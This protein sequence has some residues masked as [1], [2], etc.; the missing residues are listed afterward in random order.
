MVTIMLAIE[1]GITQ[2]DFNA[3]FRAFGPSFRAELFGPAL[4]R[5]AAVV[6]KTA[7]RPGYGFRD[8]S[9][10]L[11][12]T[13]HSARIAARY[14]G[15][16]FKRGRSGVYAGGVLSGGREPTARQA[17]LV[18][19]GHLGPYPARP[20]P[21]LRL[22]L[23]S[24]EAQQRH[25][26]NASVKQRFSIV[27]NRFIKRLAKKSSTRF[28]RAQSAASF[29]QSGYARLVSLRGFGARRGLR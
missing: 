17:H 18:E 15:K 10:S 23:R 6:R 3:A 1:I 4:G 27:A 21:Y 29:S 11:R 14:G 13:I 2:D 7:K 24:T 5:S 12:K 8:R 19:A 26:F 16:K 9:G 25:E 28:I 20:H 22:A